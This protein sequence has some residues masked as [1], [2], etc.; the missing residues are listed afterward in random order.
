VWCQL[1]SEPGAGSDLIGLATRAMD[2]DTWGV[3]GQKVRT[4]MAHH[5]QLAMFVA[6]TNPDVPKHRGLTYFIVDMSEPGVELRPLRQM[7]GKAEF[8]EVYLT[9]VH[10]S[11]EVWVGEP[12]SGWRVAVTTPANERQTWSVPHSPREGG[13]IGPVVKLWREMGLDDPVRRDELLQLWVWAQD[14]RLNS[15]KGAREAAESDP[16]PEGSFGEMITAE[17]YEEI[18]SFTVDLHGPEDLLY[19]GYEHAPA[20]RPSADD[21]PWTSPTPNGPSSGNG[22]T[23]SRPAA[24]RSTRHRGRARSR[25]TGRHQVIGTGP[26]GR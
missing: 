24:R 5:A 16:G 15:I 9:D 4:S 11:D 19:S 1:F 22:P 23:R 3:N 17:F 25:T 20:R 26:G 13:P 6:R 21:D 18:T 14:H 8:N 12:G 10:L 2:G 7:T